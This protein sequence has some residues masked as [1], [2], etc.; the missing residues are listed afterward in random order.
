[1]WIIKRLIISAFLKKKYYSNVKK[2]VNKFKAGDQAW[3]NGLCAKNNIP[4]SLEFQIG[5]QTIAV[6]LCKYF[7]FYVTFS[8]ISKSID[9]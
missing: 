7:T 1:M 2:K 4:F 8:H 5:I 9:K 6:A 3:K